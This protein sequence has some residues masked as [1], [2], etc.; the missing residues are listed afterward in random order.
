MK[1]W[2]DRT[3]PLVTPHVR[4]NLIRTENIL[5]R[6]YSQRHFGDNKN[7][8]P[9]NENVLIKLGLQALLFPVIEREE[10]VHL[11]CHTGE[12]FHTRKVEVWVLTC[13]KTPMN[14]FSHS[15]WNLIEVGAAW[16]DQRY[17]NAGV[18]VHQQ[19]ITV[20]N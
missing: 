1:Y 15:Y 3:A 18:H 19:F 11:K 6:H 16:D 10:I 4:C 7:N 14:V 2:R 12:C 20:L 9:N 5:S 17:C 8:F 13:S